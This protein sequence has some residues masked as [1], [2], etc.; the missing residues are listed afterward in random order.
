MPMVRTQKKIATCT[1][2]PTESTI[3]HVYTDVSSV[4]YAAAVYKA[5]KKM[6]LTFAKSRIAPLKGTTILRLNY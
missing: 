6:I 3:I 4:A 5:I 2:N 1:I